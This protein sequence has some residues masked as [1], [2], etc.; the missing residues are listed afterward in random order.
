LGSFEASHQLLNVIVHDLSEIALIARGCP[1]AVGLHHLP[2]L[3][4]CAGP[5]GRLCGGYIFVNRP[6]GHGGAIGVGYSNQSSQVAGAF[7]K[8]CHFPNMRPVPRV[9]QPRTPPQTD[10]LPKALY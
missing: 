6:F 8:V 3:L 7:F 9:F 4:E 10:A 1:A 5:I 2:N